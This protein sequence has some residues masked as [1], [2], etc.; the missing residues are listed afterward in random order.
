MKITVPQSLTECSARERTLALLD[1]N[2]ARELLG[3]LIA[4]SHHT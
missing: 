1:E 4:L 2:S 3:L